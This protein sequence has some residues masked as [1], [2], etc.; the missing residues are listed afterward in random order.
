MV[1]VRDTFT[2]EQQAAMIK[3]MS[4]ALIHKPQTFATLVATADH[5]IASSR[6]G[7]TYRWV[8]R[9][10]QRQRKAGA[11]RSERIGG[12]AHWVLTDE[13]RRS[14]AEAAAA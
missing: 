12:R 8:D 9:W 7:I 1:F 11:I 14:L 3:A 10:Q 4:S 13:G 2:D 6:N 5:A